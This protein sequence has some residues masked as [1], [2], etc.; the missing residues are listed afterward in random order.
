[1]TQ[2]SPSLQVRVARKEMVA[3]DIA[4]FELVDP[5]G[6]ALPPFEAGA[7]IDVTVPGGPLRQYS[8]CNDPAESHRY[9]IAVLMERE[10]RGGSRALHEQ[11]NEG[12]LLTVG[13][14]R[15]LFA[16]HEDAPSS[17]LIAGGIGITPLLAMARRLAALG[18]PF[19]LHYCARSAARA[20]FREELARA[21]FASSVRFHFDDGSAGPALDLKSLLAGAGPDVHLYTCG[22]QGFMDA[23][24]S[25]ARSQGWADAQLHY[26]FFS[27]APVVREDDGSFDVRIASTGQV[28]RVPADKSVLQVLEAEGIDIPTACE[29]G[30]CGTCMT[31]V[32]EGEPD[33][34]DYYLTPEEQAENR[35]F[36]PCCSRSKSA[37]LVLDL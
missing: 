29:Q 26:E 37:C 12:D 4:R 9:Q 16:L 17:L 20:A 23:V 24:L 6:A 5:S 35:Q 27:A 32:L 14:P 1:M 10:G 13:M 34:R 15:N 2:S 28:I 31:G 19:T 30:V 33:H 25:T 36:L 22:P 7:H 11:V 8:L 18:R 21:G 3:Q